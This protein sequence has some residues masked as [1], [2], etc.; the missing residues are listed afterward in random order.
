[1][2]A[3]RMNEYGKALVL[4]DVPVPDIK[5]DEVLVQVRACGMC[6]SDVQ[7]IDGYFRKYAD[8]P[9]PITPGHEITGIVGANPSG[10]FYNVYNGPNFI[11]FNGEVLFEGNDAVGGSHRRQAMSDDEHSAPCGDLPHVLLNG[12]LTF[13][14]ECA[15]RL[16]ED[17]NAWVSDE[18]AR[19]CDALALSAGEGRSALTDNGVVAFGQS[20]DEVVCTGKL[21]SGEDALHRHHRIGQRDVFADRRVE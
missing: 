1:M 20:K 11:V 15:R 7:L 2:K 5:P 14:I 18:S 12:S 10:L 16:V 9:T 3:A 21:G 17:E 13:V 19:H 6:R 8:I 4:E